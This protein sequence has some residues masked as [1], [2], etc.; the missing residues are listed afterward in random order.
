MGNPD[1]DLS[2][3]VTS[4][5]PRINDASNSTTLQDGDDER[6]TCYYI[7]SGDIPLRCR[8]PCMPAA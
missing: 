4:E 6:V 7:V 5:V 8:P 3:A 1:R 2:L